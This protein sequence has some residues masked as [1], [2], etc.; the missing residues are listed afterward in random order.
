M[1]RDLRNNS[2]AV[3]LHVGHGATCLT[4]F[5]KLRTVFTLSLF[6]DKAISLLFEKQNYSFTLFFVLP[7]D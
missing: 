3:S 5:V 6:Q 2:S 4:S 7:S 1:L